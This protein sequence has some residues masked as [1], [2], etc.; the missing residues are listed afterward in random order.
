MERTAYPR[1]KRTISSCE[2]Y[3]PFAPGPSEVEWT[4]GK[5]RSGE[6]LAALV[7]LLKSFPGQ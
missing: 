6:H 7:V 2:S 3:D 4:R 5:A 1:F